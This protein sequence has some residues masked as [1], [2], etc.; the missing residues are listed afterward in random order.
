MVATLIQFTVIAS[1]LMGGGG[2][3]SSPGY[4]QGTVSVSVVQTG[5]TIT[6][7]AL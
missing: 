7:S 2:Q 3:V 4:P 6:T 5:N 1:I